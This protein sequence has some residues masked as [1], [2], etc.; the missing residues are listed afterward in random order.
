MFVYNY[1]LFDRFDAPVASFAVLADDDPRW[2]P[3]GFCFEHGT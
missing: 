2:K 3:D 1:R